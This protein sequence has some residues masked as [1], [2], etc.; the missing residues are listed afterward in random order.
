MKTKFRLKALTRCLI[1]EERREDMVGWYQARLLLPT[2]PSS[3]V[4][5]FKILCFPSN[6]KG[7]VSDEDFEL[8]KRHGHIG[9]GRLQVAE[10][11]PHLKRKNMT[12]GQVDVTQRTVS[13][14]V[15][16]PVLS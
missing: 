11:Y 14:D 5:T 1:Y 8:L 9:E 2:E 15:T 16:L 12:N 7:E 6:K 3:V 13:V 10:D 4:R